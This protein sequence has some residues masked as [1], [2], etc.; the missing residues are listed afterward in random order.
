M[1]EGDEGGTYE[2]GGDPGFFGD[3][4]L[5]V[6]ESTRFGGLPDDYINQLLT[7]IV[8]Q[9]FPARF[10][11]FMDVLNSFTQQANASPM[12]L[13]GIV[14]PKL[15]EMAQAILQATK[16]TSAQLGPFGGRQIGNQMGLARAMQPVLSTFVEPTVQAGRR[17]AQ[18]LGG[19]SLI[20]PTGR[21]STATREQ[22]S[23][24]F[25]QTAQ[26]IQQLAGLVRLLYP[27]GSPGGNYGGLSQGYDQSTIP[28]EYG[29]Q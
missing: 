28:Y 2:S 14:N 4:P 11:G 8:K 13:E 19:T 22:P 7:L 24:P 25:G 16:A 10:G 12:A 15:Q 18:Q 17:G 5:E 26:S 27:Q 3:V 20:L 29:F 1:S 21:S 9:Q 6:P 23:D